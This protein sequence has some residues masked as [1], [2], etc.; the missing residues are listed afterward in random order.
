[1]S[2]LHCSATGYSAV[3]N[4]CSALFC[5]RVFCCINVYSA[6]F[7][8]RVFCCRN[9]CSSGSYSCLPFPLPPSIISSGQKFPYF[10]ILFHSL[11][12]MALTLLMP[13]ST[14]QKPSC[15]GLY[16]QPLSCVFQL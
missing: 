2:F 15:S 11:S 4:V 12:F 10:L 3:I 1:M 8:N 16:H 14:Y 7:C 9:V 6:L 5:N 13:F